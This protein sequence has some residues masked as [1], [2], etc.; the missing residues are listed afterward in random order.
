MCPLT[1]SSHVLFSFHFESWFEVR[2][3]GGKE[4]KYN[5]KMRKKNEVTT[6]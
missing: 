1:S 6:N 5:L 3:E 2:E 4:S